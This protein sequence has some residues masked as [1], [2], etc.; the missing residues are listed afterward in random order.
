METFGK[1]IDYEVEM[2]LDR[3]KRDV[4]ELRRPTEKILEKLSHDLESGEIQLII[5]DDAS[6]RIPTAIFRKIFDMAYKE[7][8]FTTLET[9]FLSGSRHLYG[10]EK[11]EKEEKIAEYL[12]Q[13]KGDIE[14]K[15][16]RPLQKVLIVTDVVMTGHSLD[17]LLEVL[18]G[19]GIQSK[20]VSIG[21]LYGEV[22]VKEI[23]ERWRAPVFFGMDYMPEVYGRPKISGVV[24]EEEEL[25]SETYKKKWGMVGTEKGVEAQYEI[26]KAREVAEDL[27]VEIYEKWK[28]MKD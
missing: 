3:V 26:N 28:K 13:V 16:G 8:G 1:K 27:A 9:R 7:R 12:E 19:M 11:K 10:E 6:G 17:P 24:K 23:S 4:L 14:K 18:N 22:S 20:V 15:F 21:I 5:G 25:F 2:E